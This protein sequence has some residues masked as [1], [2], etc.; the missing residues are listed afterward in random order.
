M[1]RVTDIAS[2]THA[3]G[4][5]RGGHILDFLIAEIL[6]NKADRATHRFIN[7]A[8]DT[9]SAG[10]SESLHPCRDVDAPSVQVIALD[11]HVAEADTDSKLDTLLLGQT[12]VS[13]GQRALYG[14]RAVQRIDGACK[15]GE[16]AVAGNLED[17]P[18]E[19]FGRR[20]E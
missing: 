12:R 5:H 16:N 9:D 19:P 15:L 6:E 17:T 20:N 2:Q 14:Y 18:S 1:I 4:V 10:V 8:R 3:I 11:D 13:I 7:V